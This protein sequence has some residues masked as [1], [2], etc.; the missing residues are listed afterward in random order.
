MCISF[1]SRGFFSGF[2]NYWR[3]MLRHTCKINSCTPS[4]LVTLPLTMLAGFS[5]QRAAC[6]N[7]YLCRGEGGLFSWWVSSACVASCLSRRIH[8]LDLSSCFSPLS[9]D[10]GEE[11]QIKGEV[12]RAEG[13][14]DRNKMLAFS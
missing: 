10:L 7:R 8:L 6:L 4:A 5:Q 9:W 14:K 12:L 1:T 2:D 13:V 11:M 3:E